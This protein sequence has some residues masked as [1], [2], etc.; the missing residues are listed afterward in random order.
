MTAFKKVYFFADAR[1][2][3]YDI[4]ANRVEDA[5]PKDTATEW[6]RWP[7]HWS[8]AP[9]PNPAD[10]V[11]AA[12]NARNG[13]AY[14]FFGRDYYRFDIAI[15]RMHHGPLKVSDYWPGVGADLSINA[16]VN[17]GND[18]VCLFH[19]STCTRFHLKDNHNLE[20]Y[21]K[22]IA[23]DWP[24]MP[25]APV[26]AALN[27][28]NGS[29]Y[30]FASNQYTRFDLGANQVAQPFAPIATDWHGMPDAPIDDAIEWSED[31]FKSAWVPIYDPSFW[32]TGKMLENNN[33]Y[34]Y[35]CNRD[36]HRMAP[37]GFGY[38]WR[39][40]LG[41]GQAVPLKPQP[42]QL[43]D[44]LLDEAAR[45][46]GLVAIDPDRLECPPGQYPVMMFRN[47]RGTDF[48][49]IRR[50]AD[51]TWSHKIGGSEATNRDSKGNRITEPRTAVLSYYNVFIRA[52]RVDRSVVRLGG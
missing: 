27:Y 41:A 7:T 18:V 44:Q 4:D 29:V 30:F 17:L 22:R 3:R 19:G 43:T 25:D 36:M 5:W 40:G 1:Y 31:D 15:E 24:G 52:Y 6:R 42:G 10:T 28:G 12:L 34:S 32:N 50:D 47:L 11:G 45:A 14:F 21:P 13:K 51:G 49:F 48:H 37:G 35:A 20:G 23:D 26:N 9:G 39:P 38:P 46:D 2:W 16:A 33:C 8:P